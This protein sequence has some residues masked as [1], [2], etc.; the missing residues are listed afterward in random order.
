MPHI[1]MLKKEPLQWDFEKEGREVRKKVRDS[2]KIKEGGL[3]TALFGPGKKGT[4]SFLLPLEVE[5]TP[6][7]GRG[8]GTTPLFSREVNNPPGAATTTSRKGGTAQ[9]EREGSTPLRLSAEK[10]MSIKS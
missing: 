9:L 2:E 10:K 1:F 8:K 5:A 6:I 7:P 4:R 3:E